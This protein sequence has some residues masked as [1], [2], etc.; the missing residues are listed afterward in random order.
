[1]CVS[2][3]LCIDVLLCLCLCVCLYV[4]AF[5]SLCKSYFRIIQWILLTFSQKVS[6]LFKFILKGSYK[7]IS[8]HVASLCFLK[9]CLLSV[10]HLFLFSFSFL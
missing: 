8:L 6:I 1:M 10:L 9:F 3:C 4:C 2:L 5:L 7:Y